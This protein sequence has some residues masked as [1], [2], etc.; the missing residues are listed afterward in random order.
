MNSATS[1][2][3]PGQT[4][5]RNGRRS[6]GPSTG[7]GSRMEPTYWIPSDSVSLL[8]VGCN[9]GD[10]LADFR[11]RYSNLELAG[12]DINH[13][14]VATAKAKVPDAE[15]L[16]GYGF[17]LP[18]A[19]GRF[20]YATCIEVIEHVP[21]ADRPGL[22]SEICRVLQPGGRLILRCPHDGIFSWLDGQNLRFQFPRLYKRFV[23]EGNRD[24]TYRAAAEELV[25]HHHFT[26]EELLS[27]AGGGWEVETCQFGGLLLFPITD[28]VRWPFYRAKR[29]DHWFV[30]LMSSVAT[31]ELAVNFGKS[32]Y[33]ILLVLKKAEPPVSAT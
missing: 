6:S 23:G 11:S 4:S 9:T 19:T 12:I 24:A 26:R 3:E 29:F 17:A 1:V 28:I 20:Q 2:P 13:D 32:S 18:F 22:L 5:E 8:D 15:I 21:A 7:R 25:R 33:G 30:K 27:I 16:Q 31:A 14:A 10:L